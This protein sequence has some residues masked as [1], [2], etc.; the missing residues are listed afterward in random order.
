MNKNTL[1]F[2]FLLAIALPN[3]VLANNENDIKKFQSNFLQR[4][5]LNPLSE[6]EILFDKKVNFKNELIELIETANAANELTNLRAANIFT[7]N[8]G[9]FVQMQGSDKI[10][11]LFNGSIII[12]F[13][14]VPNFTDYALSKEIEF[15]TDLSN[16]KRGV[17]KINNLY[18]LQL[19]IDEIKL[20][21]NVLEI[22]LDVIDPRLKTE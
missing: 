13:K 15:T 6:V 12:K 4:N 22:E 9:E 2:F 18:D 16:I 7:L 14:S 1:N 5:T 8:K 20:D 3:I 11:K 10:N 17:F 21:E 19:K